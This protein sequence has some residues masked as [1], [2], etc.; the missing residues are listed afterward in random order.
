MHIKDQVK[1]CELIKYLLKN[2]ALILILTITITINININITIT[3]IIII[4]KV[5]K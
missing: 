3:V 2:G 4:A 1:C 5:C